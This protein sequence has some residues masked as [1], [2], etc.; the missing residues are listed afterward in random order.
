M[1]SQMRQTEVTGELPAARN[2]SVGLA[3]TKRAAE[4]MGGSI[5]VDTQKGAGTCMTVRLPE[6]EEAGVA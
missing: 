2:R 4:E 5:E 1:A 6:A 3:V